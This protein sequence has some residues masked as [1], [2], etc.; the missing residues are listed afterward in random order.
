VNGGETELVAVRV[1]EHRPSEVPRGVILDGGGSEIAGPLHRAVEVVDIEVEMET[2]PAARWLVDL[3][4]GN[5]DPALVLGF[6][7][8][9]V[10]ARTTGDS[11]AEQLGPEGCQSIGIVGIDHY[12]IDFRCR[13]QATPP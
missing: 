12:G 5:R 3:L 2:T 8:D 10:G 13:T 7:P 4:E 9:E 6:E 1:G 11:D